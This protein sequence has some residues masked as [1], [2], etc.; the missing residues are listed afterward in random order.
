MKFPLLAFALATISFTQSHAQVYSLMGT[1]C[2]EKVY[3]IAPDPSN[4][5]GVY[6][7]GAFTNS[8]GGP[9]N[10][11]SRWNGTSWTAVGGGMNYYVRSI[12]AQSPTEIYVGGGFS[13]AGSPTPIGAFG[14]AKWNG[15]AWSGLANGVRGDVYSLTFY[16]SELYAGGAFDTIN[17]F[18]PGRG[19]LKWNGT[20]WV[21]LGGFTGA[22]VAG[23]PGFKVKAMQVFNGELYVGGTFVSANGTVV[24]NIAKWN[25]TSWAAVGSGTNGEVNAFAVFNGDLYVGGAFTVAGGVTV[26]GLAKILGTTYSAV[27]GGVN[28]TVNGLTSVG[29]FLYATGVFGTA[30]TV[31]AQNIAKWDGITWDN[32]GLGLNFDGYCLTPHSSELYIGGFFSVAGTVF[33]NN[34]CKILDPAVGINEIN[35]SSEAVIAPNPASESFT[36]YFPTEMNGSDFTITDFTGRVVDHGSLLSETNQLLVNTGHYASGLYSIQ[37]S[38]SRKSLVYKVIVE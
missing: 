20:A 36:I 16:N 15:S 38:N 22:G 29:P 27:S 23:A 7:G 11:I 18:N 10:Y 17:A 34:I 14:V 32:V 21:T 1:G 26:N 3:T 4:P 24:N 28:G 2:N 13:L 19:I 9:V 35:T 12:V 33:A 8:G 31:S 5:N 25:G 37:L 30:G 6:A